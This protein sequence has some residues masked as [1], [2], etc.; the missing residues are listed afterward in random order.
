MQFPQLGCSML[1][2]EQTLVGP[3]KWREWFEGPGLLSC[4]WDPEAQ[5]DHLPFPACHCPGGGH[6]DLVWQ[7]L[8]FPL[9]LPGQALAC[10]RSCGAQERPWR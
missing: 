10:Q 8:G 7:D 1:E 5:D 4:S 9:A 2:A 6:E 3:R